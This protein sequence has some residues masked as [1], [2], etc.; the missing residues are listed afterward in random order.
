MHSTSLRSRLAGALFGACAIG[1][2]MSCAGVPVEP[3]VATEHFIARVTT[4]DGAVTAVYHKGPPPIAAGGATLQASLPGVIIVGGSSP[5]TFTS[6]TP[7]SQVVINVTGYEGYYTLDLPAPVTSVNAII[8]WSQDV[9]SLQ[10][11]TA[12]GTG[13]APQG[14]YALSPI[15]AI[16]VGTGDVQVSVS[17]DSLT[18]V[19]LHVIDPSGE[20]IYYA[21]RESASGGKLDLDANA[22]CTIDSPVIN[23]ENITWPTGTAPSG[24]YIVRLD[25]WSACGKGST[26]YIVTVHRVGYPV[27]VFTGTFTGA[28]DGGGAGSGIEITR[29]TF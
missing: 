11:E 22:A 20:E 29:F 9:P 28:G 2:V 19:D 5:A 1:A 17:F 25:Y 27:Q 23:N 16:R 26:N 18:D 21:S 12:S 10:F 8:T 4:A 3:E 13:G 15:R 7:F 14:P 6:E 24:E